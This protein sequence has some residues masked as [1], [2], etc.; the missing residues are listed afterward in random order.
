M[1]A[2]RY[3]R[4]LILDGFGEN[5]QSKLAKA[6]VLVIGAGGLGCPALQY[7]AAAGVGYLGLVDHD[8]I[9]LSN[10]HRQILYTS[11]DIG[12]QKAS[13][14]AGRLREMNPEIK[15]VCHATRIEKNNILQ[16]FNAYDYVLDGSDNFGTRYL[17]N[18]ACAQLKKPLIFVAVSGYEGQLA[19][20]NVLDLNGTRTNYRDLFPI[21]PSPG[22][23]PNCE[24][25]GV[26]GVL[27]G[28][29]GS[30]AAAE[31][32]KLIT[33]IGKPL[34]GKLLHYNLLTNQQYE[35]KV[36]PGLGYT[37]E[38]LAQH[39][40]TFTEIGIEALNLL[41]QQPSTLLIDVREVNEVPKLDPKVFTQVPMSSFDAYLQTEIQQNNIVLICQHGI[42]SVHAAEVLTEKY[43]NTK[44]IYSLKGGIAKWHNYL[45]ET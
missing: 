31:A 3:E 36:L 17:V 18:D 26:L 8:T 44:N 43:E 27:P 14:A 20:F 12:K 6:K 22:E 42:R 19:I 45:M 13:V 30:M 21:P 11:A 1:E 24:E 28:I 10:L 40:A 9:E 41:R 38:D 5:A 29:I 23:I 25:N 34:I 33:G 7:L 37:F 4:Q 2:G 15:I 39:T 16:I 35:I 32:I